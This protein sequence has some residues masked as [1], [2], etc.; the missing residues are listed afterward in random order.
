M[1]SPHIHCGGFF[2][3]VCDI[4]N[5]IMKGACAIAKEAV[6][7][8]MDVAEAGVS[9][10]QGVVDV[11]KAACEAI[12]DAVKTILNCLMFIDWVRLEGL[13]ELSAR[14]A[15]GNSITVSMH[16]KIMSFDEILKYVAK[17]CTN[18]NDAVY[19]VTGFDFTFNFAEPE[20]SIVG[21]AR[22]LGNAMLGG[23]HTTPA[24]DDKTCAEWAGTDPF[25]ETPDPT[26]TYAAPSDLSRANSYT[27]VYDKTTGYKGAGWNKIGGSGFV[28]NFVSGD[29]TACYV[30]PGQ[31]QSCIAS[32]E[33]LGVSGG[34]N[35]EDCYKKRSCGKGT[36]CAY[37]GAYGEQH[38]ACGTKPGG[39]SCKRPSECASFMCVAN[40]TYD[41]ESSSNTFACDTWYSVS[42]SSSTLVL[43]SNVVTCTLSS[44]PTRA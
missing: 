27:S 14:N 2:S 24:D 41:A 20:K 8:G 26:P 37:Y 9:F 16:A 4:G 39:V 21:I 12:W 17:G 38:Y 43:L 13:L 32:T 35:R 36:T 30:H 6:E 33:T 31:N 11:V 1:H 10:A 18:F 19:H 40:G 15:D 44:R 7:V 34:S 25:P 29:K 28:V 42:V 23:S 5:D 22:S 3:F